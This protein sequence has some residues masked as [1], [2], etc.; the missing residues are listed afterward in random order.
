M[1]IAD[2]VMIACDTNDVAYDENVDLP[3][4]LQPTNNENELPPE[5][6]NKQN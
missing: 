2:S 6:I 5:L 4:V 3:N 1:P